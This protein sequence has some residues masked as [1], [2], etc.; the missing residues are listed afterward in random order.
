MLRIPTRAINLLGVVLHLFYGSLSIQAQN[1]DISLEGPPVV[2]GAVGTV[3]VSPSSANFST[4]L[5]VNISLGELGPSNQ[6]SYV[7]IK[8]PVIIRSSRSYQVTASLSNPTFSSDPEGVQP[9]DVSF[10][11]QNLRV[12][13][14]GANANVCSNNTI[15]PSYNN[16]GFAIQA[17]PRLVY[18]STLKDIL[19]AGGSGV[20]LIDGPRLS[21]FV[22]PR[23]SNN[24]YRFDLIMRIAPQFYSPF[25]SSWSILLN[26]S[27]RNPGISCVP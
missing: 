9:S 11:I 15:N 2:T 10:A 24:G 6:N 23:A 20:R 4:S 14:D 18:S 27:Q 13:G 16:N 19:N 5:L 17:T 12:A 22:S 26:I 7:S 25:N 21:A 8:V 3:S 1:F